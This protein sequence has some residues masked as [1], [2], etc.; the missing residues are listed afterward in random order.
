MNNK[1]RVLIIGATGMLG[2]V[3]S[4]VFNEGAKFDAI[5]TVR[6]MHAA[7]IL[8]EDVRGKLA[9]LDNIEDTD[10]LIELV[11]SFKPDVVIT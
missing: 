6:S 8:P 3:V 9:V 7:R 2:N 5:G 11:G 1:L 4:R 10:K